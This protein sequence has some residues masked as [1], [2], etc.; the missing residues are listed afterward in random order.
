MGNAP[1]VVN[2]DLAYDFEAIIFENNVE[3]H[4]AVA[5]SHLVLGK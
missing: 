5:I 2:L 1:L 4:V 3:S